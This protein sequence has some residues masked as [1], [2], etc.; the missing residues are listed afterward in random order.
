MNATYDILGILDLYHIH[1]TAQ[2]IPGRYNVE[3]DRLSRFRNQSE[4]HLLPSAIETIFRL[5]GTPEIDLFASQKAHVVPAYVSLD[6]IDPHAVFVNAFSQ[7][8]I[9]QLAWIFPRRA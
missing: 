4:W 8:W 9:Y 1:M 5:W 6:P 7:K 2:F 3:A